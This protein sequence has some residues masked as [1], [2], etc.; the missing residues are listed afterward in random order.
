MIF[1][2]GR[3]YWRI[4]VSWYIIIFLKYWVEMSVERT[5]K[6]STRSLDF[7]VW[8]SGERQLNITR[9]SVALK[10]YNPGPVQCE[11]RRE[12]TRKLGR[13][14]HISSRER[15]SGPCRAR[16]DCQNGV[17]CYN[18]QEGTNVLKAKRRKSPE[19]EKL[20]TC[21]YWTEVKF[22]GTKILHWVFFFTEGKKTGRDLADLN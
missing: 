7:L 9:I 14:L 5:V 2:Q 11:W 4:V 20:I 15:K 16:R 13:H 10:P 8:N 12:V 6:L 22:W 18:N 17:M 19:G 21:S 1:T 3:E